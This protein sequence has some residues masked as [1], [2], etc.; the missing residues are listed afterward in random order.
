MPMLGTIALQH[1]A[2]EYLSPTGPTT[3][4]RVADEMPSAPTTRS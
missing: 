1:V 4:S 3:A 2:P